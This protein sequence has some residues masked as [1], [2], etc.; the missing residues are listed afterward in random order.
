MINTRCQPRDR[1]LLEIATTFWRILTKEYDARAERSALLKTCA[2]TYTHTKARSTESHKL[3]GMMRS[4]ETDGSEAVG[5]DARSGSF[6][7]HLEQPINHCPLHDHH[8]VLGEDAFC[9]VLL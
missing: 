4:Y 5:V 3:K 8:A 7:C 9:L 6:L 2:K 1:I